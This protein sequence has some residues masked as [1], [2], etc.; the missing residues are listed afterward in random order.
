MAV[1]HLDEQLLATEG[2]L[3]RAR[4]RHQRRGGGDELRDVRRPRA[5]RAVE[6]VVELAPEQHDEGRSQHRERDQDA[7][8]SGE[9]DAQPEASEVHSPTVKPSPR[10]VRIRIGSPSLRRRLVT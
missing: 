10:T 4:L 7:E 9:P 2:R 1:E 5:E 8:R 6:L 3:E